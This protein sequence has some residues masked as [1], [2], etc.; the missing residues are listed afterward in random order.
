MLTHLDL[1]SDEVGMA[2]KLMALI[3]FLSNKAK[4][5]ILDHIT[6]CFISEKIVEACL[7]LYNDPDAPVLSKN[8]NTRMGIMIE[9]LIKL[10]TFTDELL[11]CNNNPHK[12]RSDLNA[13]STSPSNSSYRPNPYMANSRYGHGND[14]GWKAN[15]NPLLTIT[16]GMAVDMEEALGVWNLTLLANP[17]EILVGAVEIYLR[18]NIA[19]YVL[20]IADGDWIVV[21]SFLQ[22]NDPKR[23]ITF[24]TN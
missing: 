20:I 24:F 5:T 6:L 15:S 18:W 23:D 17:I 19:I 8:M 14:C 4:E 7:N 21:I 1:F 22:A 9:K 2:A 10:A 12:R 11:S 3:R 16:K 13:L